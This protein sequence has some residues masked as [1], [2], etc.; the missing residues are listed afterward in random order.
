MPAVQA[1]P[2]FREERHDG[3][4]TCMTPSYYLSKQA[5]VCVAG[6]ALFILD[7]LTG[8]YLS[9]DKHKAASLGD[10]VMGWPS[11][12]DGN[13]NPAVLRSLIDRGLVTRDSGAGK[14]A[15]PCVIELPSYW[16]RESEPRGCPDIKARDFYAFAASAIYAAWNKRFSPFRRTVEIIRK[17][18]DA[19][20]CSQA[21]VSELASLVRIFDWLRPLAFRKTD[22]CFLYCLALNEFLSRYKIFPLWVFGVRANP[23]RAHCW[24]Q[25]GDR[26]LTDIPYN[27]R[28]MT[29]IL[30]L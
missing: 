28:Q 3:E 18:K 29:P 4:T 20:P 7:T 21:D 27:L 10:M 19:G 24:L 14:S 26:A 16:V 22:E 23:F 17:K 11:D 30:A 5:H 1:P 9:L 8:K 12:M 15:A 2:L 6:D 13:S 25:Y